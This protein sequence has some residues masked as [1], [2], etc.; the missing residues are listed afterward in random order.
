MTGSQATV[1]F[2]VTPQGE[3][4]AIPSDA[5]ARVPGGCK[6]VEGLLDGFPF[7]APLREDRNGRQ[8]VLSRAQREAALPATGG[9]AVELTRFDA[10]PE[11]RVPSDLSAAL[12]KEPSALAVW[13]KVTP[14]ARREWVRWVASGKQDKTRVHRIE[15]A[16]DMLASGK[17]RPCCFP[18]INWVTKGKVT[19]EETWIPLR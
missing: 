17:R 3:L 16:C 7:R 5:I 14:M 15:T 10:E 18:G 13:G 8:I 2:E 4:L 12:E 11:V 19:A 1:R 6:V 9:V